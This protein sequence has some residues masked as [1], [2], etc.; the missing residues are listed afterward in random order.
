[1]KQL[2]KILW[3]LVAVLVALFLFNRPAYAHERRMVGPYEFVVGFIVEPAFESLKNG[4]DLR[5]S[6]PGATE[7][8]EATPIEG[9]EETL[10]VEVTHVPSGV[11]R[12]MA[13]RT[14]FRDPGHYTN[15]WIPTAPG[16]Y[17]FRFFGTVEELEVDEVF[18]SGEG[19][20]NIEANDE[21]YFPEAVPEV[22]EV[23]GAVRG[24][25]SSAEE[26][27]DAAT[28][29]ESAA[30]SVR[31]LAIA[32]IVLGVVGLAAG[33]AGLVMARRQR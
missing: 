11:S 25:Q 6:I 15:D 29:A 31:T 20:S 32:G 13:L 16:Q 28:A 10:Q 30:A 26:A 18:E 17:R 19:F 1:M 12:I 24:A 14:I 27:L 22:R 23:E 2:L 5:V 21:L 4:V 3:P 9:L 33:S 7:E 8:E